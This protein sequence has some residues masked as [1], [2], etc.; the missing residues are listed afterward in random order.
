MVTPP[1]SFSAVPTLYLTPARA[2][3]LPIA[4]RSKTERNTMERR[5]RLDK[6]SGN[7]SRKDTLDVETVNLY[8][9]QAEQLAHDVFVVL[10]D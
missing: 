10:T 4:G 7:A 8:L 3:F 9:R 5:A 1:C 6:F 2:S